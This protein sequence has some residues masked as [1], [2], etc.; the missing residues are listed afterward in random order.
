MLSTKFHTDQRSDHGQTVNPW[1]SNRG[2]QSL[3]ISA[4]SIWIW[5]R[6]AHVGP[7]TYRLS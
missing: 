4:V 6:I 5:N 7:Y 2:K 3:K 1:M